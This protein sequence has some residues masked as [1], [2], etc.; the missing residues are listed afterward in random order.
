MVNAFVGAEDNTTPWQVRTSGVAPPGSE[1]MACLGG[2]IVNV[3]DPQGS[4][5]KEYGL[6]SSNQQGR[7]NGFEEVSEGIV[8]M[9]RVT[10]AEGSPSG[11]F[12]L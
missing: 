9:M 4:P 6:T 5:R 10:T 7:P 8:P 3:G 12:N 2:I 1:S 11:N